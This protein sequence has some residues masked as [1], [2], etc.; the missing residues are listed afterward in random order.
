M[1]ELIRREAAS[2]PLPFSGERLTSGLAEWQVGIEHHHRYLLARDFCRGRDV[3]DVASGE[4]YGTALLAQVARSAIGVEIDPAAVAA[5]RTEFVRPNLRYEVGDARALPLPDASIDVAV[6]FETLE[7]ILEHDV[8]LSELHRVLRPGGLLVMSTPDRDI[9]SPAGAPPNPYHVLELTR[10]EFEALLRRHFAHAVFAAQRGVLGTVILG[11][12]RTITTRFFER[13]SDTHIEASDQLPRA[14]YLI[15]LASD[16][17]LPPLPDSAYI[18]RGDIDTDMLGRADAETRLRAAEASAA[19]ANRRADALKEEAAT[20]RAETEAAVAAVEAARARAEAAVEAA[21]A[22]AGVEVVMP[23]G[24]LRS[25]QGRTKRRARAPI[26]TRSA[27]RTPRLRSSEH[28]PRRPRS[29]CRRFFA[30]P[31]GT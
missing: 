18:H 13:R 28:V 11:A 14:P 24:V 1:G 21:R 2:A 17:D 8:F 10:A 23:K 6:S 22:R 25:R 4:G 27:R 19:D 12:S 30:R 7:H 5:A 15:A 31:A 20:A 3:L 29:T 16:G 26:K 9:Y